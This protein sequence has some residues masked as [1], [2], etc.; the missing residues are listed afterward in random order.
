MYR[1]G[2]VYCKVWKLF[3]HNTA[4]NSI[5]KSPWCRA[6]PCFFI[7]MGSPPERT[8]GGASPAADIGGD[9]PRTDEQASPAVFTSPQSGGGESSPAGS[10]APRTDEQ[11]PPAVVPS[12]EACGGRSSQAGGDALRPDGHEPP[13]ATSSPQAGGGA[14]SLAGSVAPPAGATGGDEARTVGQV[15]PADA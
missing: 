3:P 11:A 4:V 10:D 15:P 13:A 2:G 14:S 5:N 9:A 12:P 8:G 7:S 6:R 1:T